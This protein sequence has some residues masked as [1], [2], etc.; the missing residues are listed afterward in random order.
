MTPVNHPSALVS[1]LRE[2]PK[3]IH[4]QH[5]VSVIPYLSRQQ[6]FQEVPHHVSFHFSFPY[7]SSIRVG[8]LYSGIPGFRSP[9]MML[10]L[11]IPT[12]IFLLQSFL[13]GA[14]FRPS[15][16][17]SL[18]FSFTDF[19]PIEAYSRYALGLCLGPFGG[20]GQWGA[21]VGDWEKKTRN[22][23]GPVGFWLI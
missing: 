6:V 8:F 11:Q 5:P 23:R 20:S 14:G 21:L 2:S 15:T 12:H 1:F 7:K 18:H 19:E 17:D 16:V 4:A 10:P 9:G 3:P 22:L 13:G